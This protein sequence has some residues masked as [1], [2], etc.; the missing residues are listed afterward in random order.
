MERRLPLCERDRIIA[1]VR[2]ESVDRQRSHELLVIDE[3]DEHSG[4]TA[5]MRMTAFPAA[6]VSWMQCSGQVQAGVTPLE[7]GVD[8]DVFLD[9][10]ERRGVTIVGLSVS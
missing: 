7:L 8:C 9:Q 10:L 4:L 6:I 2:F 1:Q 3:Y 5:M